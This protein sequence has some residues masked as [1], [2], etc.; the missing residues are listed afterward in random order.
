MIHDA[1]D[2]QRFINYVGSEIAAEIKNR[3]RE[4]WVA[5]PDNIE[6]YE[7]YWR[8]PELQNG[9]LIAKPDPIT[10]QM[11][12]KVAPSEVPQTLLM[13]FQRGSQDIREIIGISET[14]QLQGRDISGK[15]RRERRMEGAAAAFVFFDNLAQA[16]EQSGRVVLDLLPTVYGEY[17]RTVNVKKPDGR[18]ET[19][20]LNKQQGE[21]IKNKI[22]EG[23]YDVEIDT[24]ASFAVQKEVALEFFQQTIAANPQTFNLIADLWAKNL[25]V[26]YMPQIADRFKTLVPPQIIAQEE[27]KPAPAPQPSPQE[28]MMQQQLQMQQA[29]MAEKAK[30][31]QL[32]EEELQIKK[33]KLDLEQQDLMLKAQTQMSKSATEQQYNQ[34]EAGKA[35]LDY[36][37][38]QEKLRHDFAKHMHTLA[39]N[40]KRQY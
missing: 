5:T 3:R 9:A 34:L 23:D 14:E 10:Q 28:M 18:T 25:D 13:Q 22:T 2:A 6:G 24:G 31:I 4:Q 38:A 36:A 16:T 26:Q 8:T 40:D 33:A 27:G 1:K 11:P 32:A 20:V 19:L 21:E 12:I 7:E 37:V 29:E 39:H 17:E 15:A 35:Q 30:K